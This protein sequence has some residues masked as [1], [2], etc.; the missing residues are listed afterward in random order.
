M[1]KVEFADRTFAVSYLD[2]PVMNGAAVNDVETR[3]DGARNGALKNMTID[4]NKPT[5]R[6]EKPMNVSGYPPREIIVDNL[7]LKIV[8]VMR[9]VLVKNRGYFLGFSS[10]A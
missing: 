10:Y 3:L 9:V 1:A 2:V 4:G 5:L 6:S 7:T 8:S